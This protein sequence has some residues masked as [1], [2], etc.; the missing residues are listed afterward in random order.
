VDEQI[1]RGV[2]SDDTVDVGA[3]LHAR[4]ARRSGRR[5]VWINMFR[6]QCVML[7][8]RECVAVARFDR[9]RQREDSDDRNVARSACRSLI[10]SEN[11]HCVTTNNNVCSCAQSWCHCRHSSMRRRRQA[12][13][14]S[15]FACSRFVIVCFCGAVFNDRTNTSNAVTVEV[16]RSVAVVERRGVCGDCACDAKHARRTATHRATQKC[17]KSVLFTSL[18]FC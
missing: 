3:L 10:L 16:R 17:N 11:V 2:A 5:S 12:C 6:V 15:T 14:S 7:F 8:V 4:A 1:E 18:G 9:D 13:P